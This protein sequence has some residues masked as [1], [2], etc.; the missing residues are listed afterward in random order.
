M[1][2]IAKHVG[3]TRQ[4]V[5]EIVRKHVLTEKIR[6]LITDYLREDAQK[7][8]FVGKGLTVVA[9]EIERK[10]GVRLSLHHLR[11]ILIDINLLEWYTGKDVSE[12][13][14][15]KQRLDALEARMGFL[16]E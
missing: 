9:A 2:D 16:G 14:Q 4:R 6:R 5:T 15:I 11:V 13:E 7:T 12:I 8:R 10:Y 3:C 1:T